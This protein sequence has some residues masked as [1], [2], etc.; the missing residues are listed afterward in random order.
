[1]LTFALKSPH[2]HR[3]NSLAINTTKY[4]E[5]TIQDL[6]DF[7]ETDLPLDTFNFFILADSSNE[8]LLSRASGALF[9]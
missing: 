4:M 7:P 6:F 8:K 2:L 1:M 3:A 9:F 5:F